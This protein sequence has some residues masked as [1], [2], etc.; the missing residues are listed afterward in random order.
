MNRLMKRLVH[1]SWHTSHLQDDFI[2]EGLRGPILLTSIPAWIRNDIHYKVW[3]EITCP[4]L[5]SLY[6][7]FHQF[8]QQVLHY[9][10]LLHA[11]YNTWLTPVTVRG[12]QS[13][14]CGTQMR[15]WKAWFGVNCIFQE[16]IC[17]ENWHMFFFLNQKHIYITCNKVMSKYKA[18][19]ILSMNVHLDFRGGFLNRNASRDESIETRDESIESGEK[20]QLSCYNLGYCIKLRVISVIQFIILFSMWF[21]VAYYKSTVLETALQR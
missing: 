12:S 2:Y 3:G 17:F 16:N 21:N 6:I 15:R 7:K 20:A 19:H 11:V 5:I 4:F 9:R 13:T 18:M 1:E 14:A 10:R 8:V